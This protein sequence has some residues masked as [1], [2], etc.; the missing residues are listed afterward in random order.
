MTLT[1]DR[2]PREVDMP[3][4]FAA[5]LDAE[6]Q[7]RAFF[8]ALPNSLQRYHAGNVAGAKTEETRSRRIEKAIA[9]FLAGKKR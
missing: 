2:S 8:D 4:D 9:L 6:P 5:A 3:G 1:V 7:A